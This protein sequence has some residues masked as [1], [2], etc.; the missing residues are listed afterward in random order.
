MTVK[1]SVYLAGPFFSPEQNQRL[2]QI[3][4]LLK[5]NPTINC[6]AIF[7]PGDPK[8]QYQ[9][10]EI[11]SCQWQNA[12]FGLDVRQIKQADIVIAILDYQVEQA[13]FEVDSGTAWECG[14]AHALNKPIFLVRY[15]PELPLNLMLA[16]SATGVFIGE[17]EIQQLTN[18]NFYEL[19]TK[20]NQLPVF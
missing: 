13:N 17:A 19:Q 14:Y 15:Q 3:E 12:T 16:V 9:G 20:F 11:G 10:A 8:Y 18:Y 7:K 6:E 2:D 5:Q 1:K 4:T